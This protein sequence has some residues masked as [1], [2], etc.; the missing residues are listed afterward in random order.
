MPFEGKP[1]PTFN[2]DGA[3]EEFF[4]IC[5]SDDVFGIG[6]LYLQIRVRVSFVNFLNPG[7]I[8]AFGITVLGAGAPS[9]GPG[10]INGIDVFPD[11]TSAKFNCLT[12]AAL[13][14][15]AVCSFAY[16]QIWHLGSLQLFG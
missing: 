10:C 2:H 7:A 3:F 8:G 5:G 11:M 6:P 14:P 16:E 1:I 13:S 9:G 12:F 4:E 15:I